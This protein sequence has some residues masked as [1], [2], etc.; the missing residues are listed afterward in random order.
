[1]NEVTT[2]EIMDKIHDTMLDNHHVKVQQI[3]KLRNI[4]EE[5]IFN[6]LHIHL[7]MKTI[8]ARWM[9]CLLVVDQIWTLVTISKQ[10][11][12]MFKYNQSEFLRR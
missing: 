12:E 8:K 11:L 6:I 2:E 7:G 10:Y 3:T 5:D 1:M 9:P 4:S